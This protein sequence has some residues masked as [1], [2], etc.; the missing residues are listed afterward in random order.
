MKYCSVTYSSV[1]YSRAGV[2]MYTVTECNK[3]A[4]MILR[5]VI[6][7]CEVVT[8]ASYQMVQ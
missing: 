7:L 4:A 3:M 8:Y 6:S 2:P 1:T 5:P